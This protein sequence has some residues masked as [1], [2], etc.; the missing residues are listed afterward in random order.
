M[1]ISKEVLFSY[2]FAAFI[3][4]L[5]LVVITNSS[6]SA[7]VEVDPGV[8]MAESIGERH[9]LTL[10]MITEEDELEDTYV[11]TDSLNQK[12]II[13]TMDEKTTYMFDDNTRVLRFVKDGTL[14]NEQH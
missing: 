4:S 13:Y 14:V 10:Q 11:F 5:L 8:E 1:K 2:M 3:G 6:E 12:V 9:N 7:K